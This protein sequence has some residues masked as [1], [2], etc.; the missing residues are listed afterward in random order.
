[1]PGDH[2]SASPQPAVHGAPEDGLRRTDTSTTTPVVAGA[3]SQ[4]GIAGSGKGANAPAGCWSL[5]EL[6]R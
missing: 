6:R 3:V 4:R 2:V 1:M 5:S